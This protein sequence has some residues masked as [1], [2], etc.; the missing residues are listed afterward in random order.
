MDL[1]T[2][3]SLQSISDELSIL[4]GTI[5]AVYAALAYHVAKQ[6]M[7]SVAASELSNLKIKARETQGVAEKSLVG[8]KANCGAVRAQWEAYACRHFPLLG[9]DE[10]LRQNTQHISSI[11]RRGA[12]AFRSISCDSAS[13][14]SLSTS[15]L[16]AFIMR[17]SEVSLTIDR[18]S[19]NLSPPAPFPGF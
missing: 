3:F 10:Q 5:G 9:R 15:E 1:K 19:L 13:I 17:A 12:E 16:Q 7:R 18:L 8:L 4:I 6:A 11:E 2:I 14:D